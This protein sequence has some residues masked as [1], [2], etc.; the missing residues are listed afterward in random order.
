MQEM[1]EE[2]VPSLGREDSLGKKMTTHSSILAWEIPRTEKPRGYNPWGHRR[3]GYDLET[4][5]QQRT[6]KALE[7]L[8]PSPK[9]NSAP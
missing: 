6:S 5:Q 3:V 4:K 7:F 8:F 9:P 2:R 1:Q